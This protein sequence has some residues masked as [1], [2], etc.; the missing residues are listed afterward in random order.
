MKRGTTYMWAPLT[1]CRQVV[2]APVEIN[3]EVGQPASSE[4][5]LAEN[6]KNT[7]MG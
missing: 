4:G 2:V 6:E 1:L 5:S 7:G 3:D